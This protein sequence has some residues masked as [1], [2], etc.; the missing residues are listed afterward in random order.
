MSR[1]LIPLALVC[2]IAAV[3]LVPAAPVPTHLMPKDPP[4]YH[5]VQKGARWVYEG[6][7][8]AGTF[9]VTAVEDEKEGAQLLTIAEVSKDGKEVPYQKLAV[10]RRGILLLEH[11]VRF[12]EPVWLL[13]TPAR[14]GDKWEF[15]TSGPG[16]VE[17]KGTVRVVE[18]EAVEVPAG[19][20][21]AVRVEEQFT[22]LANGKPVDRYTQVFWYST[23]QPTTTPSPAWPS[24]R[25]AP[26][27]RRRSE[28]STSRRAPA[29][30][31]CAFRAILSRGRPRRRLS[32]V[33]GMAPLSRF[34]AP[35]REHTSRP[36][37]STASTF[38]T[39]R[40]HQMAS[41]SP[42][43]VTKRPCASGT[44]ATGRSDRVSRG[45]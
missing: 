42:R 8:R 41:A 29:Y 9:E 25:R 44:R 10:S 18:V 16:I 21:T 35:T 23:E 12:D 39:S 43:S 11:P 40:Y 34:T 26:G 1:P 4:L 30:W 6:G 7:A 32:R 2:L 36:S 14:A 5:P 24:T 15:R 22:A 17:G 37:N 31:R 20:F 28:S 38:R 45:R 33:P 27:W 3:P 19:K 13:K